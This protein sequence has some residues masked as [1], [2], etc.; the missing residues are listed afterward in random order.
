VSVD[1]AKDPAVLKL[2]RREVDRIVVNAARRTERRP[3]ICQGYVTADPLD[4]TPGVKAHNATAIH[5]AWR[6]RTG[7]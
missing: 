4:P 3:C 1:Y 6:E 2:Q 5:E 7:R